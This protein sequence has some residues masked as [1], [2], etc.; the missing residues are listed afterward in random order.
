MNKVIASMGALI[1]TISVVLFAIC[2]LISFNF[3]S[4]FVCMLLPIGYIMMISGFCN[5]SDEKHRVAANVGTTFA[6]VYTVLIF[7]VYFAQTTSVRLDSLDEQA[8]RIL[9]Y[10]RGGLFFDY[11]LLGYGMMALS[12]FFIGLT[13]DTKTKSDKWLK[14]LM[15]FHGVFFFPCFIMPMTGIFRSMSDGETN[16]GGVIALEFWCTYFTPIGILS[17]IHFRKNN[18]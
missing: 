1:V 5:E 16:M 18:K 3:G 15:L 13:I 9:D 2:M 6:T 17:L 7:L 12:T 10:S 14:Y 8:V 4:Y 11:D